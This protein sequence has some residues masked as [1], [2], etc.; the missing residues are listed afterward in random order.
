ML[1]PLKNSA[2]FF[3]EIA[4]FYYIC[5]LQIPEFVKHTCRALN[6]WLNI[7]F[8]SSSNGYSNGNSNPASGG[9]L[10]L[11]GLSK[12]KIDSWDSMG[13]LGLTSKIWNDSTTKRQETFMEST[14]QFLREET[15]SYIMWSLAKW[16][17]IHLNG[18]K[19]IY[20]VIF[21]GELVSE[22]SVTI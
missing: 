11:G 2:I 12:P 16:D 5:G 20:R 4:F 10:S 22:I 21:I 19:K 13:I 6:C 8:A 7:Y 14:G 1:F 9:G 17:V 15:T 3:G 18:P